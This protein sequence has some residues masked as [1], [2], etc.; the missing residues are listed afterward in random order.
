[1]AQHL[2]GTTLN[3]PSSSNAVSRFDEFFLNSP[4][5]IHDSLEHTLYGIGRKWSGVVFGHV[6]KHGILAL[7]LVDGHF[8]A[9][10]DAADLFHDGSTLVQKI[11][12]A[13]IDSVD[14]LAAGRKSAHGIPN[15]LDIA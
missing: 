13:K 11:Q 1:M 5:L 12:N 14:S 3:A 2:P 7:W 9:S 4:H 10:F 15:C 8:G 6:P